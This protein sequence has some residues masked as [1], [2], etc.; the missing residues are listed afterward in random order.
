MTEKKKLKGVNYF[1]YGIGDIYG[2]G[3]FLIINTLFLFFLTDIA[4]LP[5]VLAGLVI[6]FGKFW[7]AVT[8][9]IMGYISDNT[10]T[11]FGRRRI[12]FITGIIPVFI[13]FILIW[14]KV[15][16]NNNIINFLYYAFAYM[17]FSTAFTLVMIPY[18]ALN[19]DMTGEYKERTK[20]T[21]FRMFFSQFSSLICGT[22]PKII[23]NKTGGGASG[24][25]TMAIIFGIFFSVPWLFVFLGTF[26]DENRYKD[27][28]TQKVS[29]FFKGILSVFKNKSFRI[30]IGMYIAAY[31]AMDFIMALFIYYLQKYLN[32]PSLYVPCMGTI[33]ITQILF[34]PLYVFISNKFGKGVA[35]RIGL[36]LWA[37]GLI[38]SFFLTPTST[39]F[40]VLI[41]CF[42]IGAG[43]S[44]GV[45]VP[46]AILPSV[47]E[48]DTLI[49]T[50]NRAG[51]Y[52]GAMTLIRKTV[53]A[54]ALALIGLYLQ[55]IKYDANAK[56]LSNETLNG[57]KA[58]FFLFPFILL[59]IG[60]L[61]GLKFKV[62]PKTFEVIKNEIERLK[63]GD[64]KENTSEENKKICE[65]LTGFSFEK[66]FNKENLNI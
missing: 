57:I 36:P 13:T 63:K 56:T 20:L 9:P 21:G 58:G 35:F 53:Q 19:A 34:L 16:F 50:K 30:H 62:T 65:T 59:F 3:S 39:N 6:F 24:F 45:F 38:I 2:G 49:T 10:R 17:F 61:I 48:I 5:P 8:D 29:E 43:L 26:E 4:K 18:S 46:Y 32:K 22:L 28:E 64:K 54:I 27:Q 51:L 60:F 25:L 55:L 11:K 42:I 23:I 41:V 12:Y 31:V 44:A 15:D 14:L 37:L 1:A 7:D 66:L 33:L 40:I 47:V 52:S